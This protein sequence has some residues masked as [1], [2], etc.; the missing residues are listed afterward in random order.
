MR[1]KRKK[2][3]FKSTVNNLTTGDLSL[4]KF[5]NKPVAQPRYM[6]PNNSFTINSLK[7]YSLTKIKD[8]QT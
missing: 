2:H 8:T 7:R 4:L 1:G 3:Y 6:I 5:Q